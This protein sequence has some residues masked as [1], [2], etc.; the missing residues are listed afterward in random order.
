MTKSR[1]SYKQRAFAMQTVES[2]MAQ[3]VEEGDCL[4]W[5]GRFC[6]GVPHVSHNKA[7]VS[8]RR[9]LVELSGGKVSKTHRYGCTC[10]N[11]ACVSLEHVKPRSAK[12][13]SA[14]MNRVAGQPTASFILKMSAYARAR[15]K[16]N[17]DIAWE[18]RL[19]DDNNVVLSA[20]YGVAR[21]TIQKIKRNEVWKE[22]SSPFA[23]LGAR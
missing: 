7:T 6:T 17:M 13:H 5:Q 18:I 16:I 12:Q 22:M 15:A 3:T 4:I 11:S 1:G 23:G 14:M 19:S 2:L 21:A 20:R 9:L 10:L 8:V